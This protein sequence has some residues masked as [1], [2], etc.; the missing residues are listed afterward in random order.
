MRPESSRDEPVSCALVDKYTV[1][2]AC[3]CRSPV[4]F[5]LRV[6]VLA[7]PGPKQ[8]VPDEAVEDVAPPEPPRPSFDGESPPPEYD[9]ITIRAITVA[10]V[11]SLFVHLLVILLPA[12]NKV[13]K[14]QRAPADEQGPLQ[15][16]IAQQ[17]TPP[18]GPQAK[19]EPPPVAQQQQPT[20]VQQRPTPKRPQTPQRTPQLAV[21]NSPSPFAVPPPVEQPQPQ[22]QPQVQ[23][24]PKPAV[25]DFASTV[26][27]QQRA[28]RNANGGQPDAV[29]ESDD[30]KASRIAKA[31][32]L[33]QQRSMNPGTD[34]DQAGGIFDLRHTGFTDAEFVFNGWNSTFGRKNPETHDVRVPPGG[35]IRIAV[36]REMIGIIRKQRPDTFEWY[37][38]NRG[39]SITMSARVQDQPELE[40]FLM[41]EFYP[42][43]P[44]AQGGPPSRR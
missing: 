33:A 28:R 40:T 21:R 44:R 41:T 1:S 5:R 26:A 23:T 43:D 37:S 7:F 16:S 6:K 36:I 42:Q 24:P 29:L 3:L 27:A 38:Q 34:P 4:A 25:D 14:E 18:P 22:P 11:L 13:D 15:V 19:P 32:I 30:E 31:N 2:D 20:P 17:T 8:R 10:I 39:K 35:D 12:F 9:R